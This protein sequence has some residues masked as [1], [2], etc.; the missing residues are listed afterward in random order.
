MLLLLFRNRPAIAAEL[1]RQSLR[2]DLPNYSEVRIE[3]A[4][5]TDATPAEYRADLVV[6]LVDDVPVMGIIVEVQLRPDPRK[7]Y[8][9]PVY[10]C[11]LR[12]RLECP[13][14]LLVLTSSNS[15]AEW[16][17]K[18][19]EV[20]PGG[21]LVPLVVGPKGMP[22]VTEPSQAESNPELAVLSVMAHGHGDQQIAIRI[23]QAAVQATAALKDDTRVLYFD[24]VEAA[25][26]E[27]AR[28]AFRMIPSNY[29]FQGPTYK[30][31]FAAGEAKGLA[32]GI[33]AILGARGLSPTDAKHQQLTACTDP[34]VLQAWLKKAAVVESVEEVFD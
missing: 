12:A 30:E 23:A 19:I 9:W 10:V 32:T 13:C 6:L 28:K 27:A 31:G 15:T 4:D 18:P 33:L 3:S 24:L 14:C 8:S 16:A 21:R 26:G 20:G 11:E 5:F 2:I 7:R 22:V 34:Q 17:S 1:L 29:K 25:L